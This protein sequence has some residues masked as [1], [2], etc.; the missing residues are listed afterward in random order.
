MYR[1]VFVIERWKGGVK[2]GAILAY[3][4]QE[5]AEGWIELISKSTRSPEDWTYTWVEIQVLR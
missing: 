4:T 3:D 5:R 1:T 2:D